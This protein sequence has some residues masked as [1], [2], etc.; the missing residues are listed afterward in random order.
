M[1][2]SNIAEVQKY[3]FIQKLKNLPFIQKVILFGSRARGSQLSRSDIDLAIVCPN[4][5]KDQWLEIITIIDTADTL[6]SIDCVNFDM[7]DDELKKR[8]II[9]G[10]T[11]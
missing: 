11:L 4:I 7:I 6:L 2:P 9:D 3:K 10:V 8:I 1:L 5:S